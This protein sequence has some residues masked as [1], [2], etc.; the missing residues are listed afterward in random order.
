MLLLILLG[1]F[2][3]FLSL[4]FC[5]SSFNGQSFRIKKAQ[6]YSRKSASPYRKQPCD[7]LS[8]FTSFCRLLLYS[9][10]LIGVS[11][12]CYGAYWNGKHKGNFH[13]VAHYLIRIGIALVITILLT[14]V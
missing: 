2:T 9:F 11:L 14:L 5:S 3:A 10:G 6:E 4:A 7:L 12:I 13:L 1:I 8:S